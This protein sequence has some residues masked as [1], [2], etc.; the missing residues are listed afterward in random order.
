MMNKQ[1]IVGAFIAMYVFTIAIIILLIIFI[2]GSSAIREM[3]K[4]GGGIKIYGESDS[5]LMNLKDYME[6]YKEKIELKILTDRE[7]NMDEARRRI[8]EKQ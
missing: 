8:Y 7:I 4:S 5:G 6:D 2:F 3:D 1:G